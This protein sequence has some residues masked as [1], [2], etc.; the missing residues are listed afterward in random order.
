LDGQLDI[1]TLPPVKTVSPDSNNPVASAASPM[2]AAPVQEFQEIEPNQLPAQ[3]QAITL[4][5]QIKG[6]ID[7]QTAE[8]DY[9]CFRF[10]AQAGQTWVIEIDAARSKSELDSF[11][12][13]L[14]EDGQRIERV[15]LQA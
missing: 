11:V 10:S 12:E 3:A 6:V 15:R 1:L 13:V 8:P 9:D 5:A 14:T 2:T 7:S 4:P